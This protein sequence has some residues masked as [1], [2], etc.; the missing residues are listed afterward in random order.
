MDQPELQ[1]RVTRRIRELPEPTT[2]WR[3]AGAVL[4][5][6]AVAVAL[7][8][9]TLSEATPITKSQLA[10]II[11]GLCLV[12][13]VLCFLSHWDTNR[14]RKRKVIEIVDESDDPA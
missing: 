9:A 7:S 5:G 11:T 13:A 4:T 6:I 12:L 2:V 10:W 1:R 3:G 8:A 14:G